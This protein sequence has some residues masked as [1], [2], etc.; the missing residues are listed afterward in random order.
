MLETTP[1]GHGVGAVESLDRLMR[2]LLRH[3]YRVM[4][5]RA[6]AARRA[7]GAEPDIALTSLVSV[8]ES[9]L[10][11]V[12]GRVR[13]LDQRVLTAPLSGRRCI[14]W[15]VAVTEVR[16][17]ER[18]EQGREIGGESDQIA[19]VLDDGTAQAVIDLEHADVTA[20]FDH[21]ATSQGASF[22]DV[23]RLGTLERLLAWHRDAYRMDITRLR[24]RERVVA[25]DED[26]VVLG[27]AMLEPDHD[28]SRPTMYRDGRALRLRF[29]GTAPRPLVIRTRRT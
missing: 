19:F 6:S 13:P 23:E 14:Y 27:A 8:T 29:R 24:Y 15:N 22:A 4:T 2:G 9:S 20:P 10:V 1:A 25:V 16:G 3:L 18:H 21:P 5:D 12:A 17:S 26:V 7:H 28:V 11:R